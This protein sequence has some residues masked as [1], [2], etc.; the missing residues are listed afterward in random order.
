MIL[1][2]THVLIWWL[3]SPSQLS[4]T[5]RKLIESAIPAAEIKVSAI[6]AWEI[7][8]LVTRGRL[9]LGVPASEWIPRAAAL[10]FVEFVSIDTK[11][12]LRAVHLPGELHPDPADRL[13]AATALER[14]WRLVTKDERLRACPFLTTVW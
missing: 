3:S 1:L 8:L 4:P 14:G 5:A 9:T 2:D 13:I 12:A 10:P 7:A 11:I 6:S